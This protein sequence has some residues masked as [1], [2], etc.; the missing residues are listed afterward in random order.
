MLIAKELISVE[1]PPLKTSDTGLKALSWMDEFKVTHLPI[2]NNEDLL[3]LISDI[4]ILDLD[5][6]E[7]SIGNHFTSLIKPYVK[8]TDHIY[9]VI[10]QISS[11]K[12][13]II[14][15]VDGN[16]KYLG[17]ITLHDLV[18]KMSGMAS[19]SDPGGILVLEVNTNDY[20]LSQIAQIV[21]SNNAIILSSYVTSFSDST[22]LEVTIKI[23]NTDLTRVMQTFNRYNYTIKASI[24]QSEF[25]DD[26]RQR[27][28]QLMNYL[29]I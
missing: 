16:N 3:G 14:P 4:D 15:V 26:L 12:L 2:V 7:E 19:I 24:Y 28:D 5:V 8:E 6:P 20:S 23:N 29:N 17:V 21:E 9:E 27:Y 1:I 10:K 22:K 11:L 25:V 13:S 18:H